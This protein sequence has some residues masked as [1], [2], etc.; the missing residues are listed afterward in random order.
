MKILPLALVLLVG[1][2]PAATQEVA[3]RRPKPADAARLLAN[4][5]AQDLIAQQIAS[6]AGIVLD[7]K[8]GPLA[9][10]TDPREG[11][12]PDD[13]LH[14]IE[15]RRDPYFDRHLYQGSH[16]AVAAAGAVAIGAVTEAAELRRTT[17]RL[18]AALRPLL[19]AAAALNAG[20]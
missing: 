1:A 16:E 6:L 8:V 15:Q 13:T 10:L 7:T 11:I 9:A 3:P 12:R 20:Q 14:S 2:S 4:P 5:A 17:A 18:R 19:G